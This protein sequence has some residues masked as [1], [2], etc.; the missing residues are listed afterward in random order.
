MQNIVKPIQYFTYLGLDKISKIIIDFV[1]NDDSLNTW[2]VLVEYK[3]ELYFYRFYIDDVMMFYRDALDCYEKALYPNEHSKYLEMARKIL[4]DMKKKTHN[5]EKPKNWY[6]FL[7]C[8]CCKTK[9]PLLDTDDKDSD[10][11]SSTN[12]PTNNIV[13]DDDDENDDDHKFTIN[14]GAFPREDEEEEKDAKI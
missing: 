1:D 4:K 13:N 12:S 5:F 9:P 8:E 3:E 11:S 14:F 2:D 10:T 7:I 6:D